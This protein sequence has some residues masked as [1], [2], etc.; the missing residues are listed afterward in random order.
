MS[1][2]V[3][4]LNFHAFMGTESLEHWWNDSEREKLRF[5]EKSVPVAQ[6]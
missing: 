1:V 3:T 4:G 5:L 6:V 2:D